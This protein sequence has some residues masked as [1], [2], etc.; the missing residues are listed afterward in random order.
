MPSI[1][2]DAFAEY[3]ARHAPDRVTEAM[4][5]VCADLGE[6]IDEFVAAASR[7]TMKRSEW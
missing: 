5:R 1:Y 2:G 6:G 7:R 4:S 3:L